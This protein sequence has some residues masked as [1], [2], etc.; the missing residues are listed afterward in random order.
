MRVEVNEVV[1]SQYVS[2]RNKRKAIPLQAWI[3]TEVFRQLKHP[4]SIQLAHKVHKVVTPTLRPLLPQEIFLAFIS[5]RT[6]FNP[7]P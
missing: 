1:L 2:K 4:I 7:K 3:G 5:L 6:W